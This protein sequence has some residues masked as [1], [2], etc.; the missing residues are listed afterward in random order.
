[1]TRI[2]AGVA[3][4]RRLAVP[5]KGTRPTSDRAREALFS[6]LAALLEL[7]GARVLDLYAGTG[8]VG[9]EALSR[10]AAQAVFVEDDRTAV[11]VLRRN[12]A[13]LDLPGAEVVRRRVAAFLATEPPSP[14]ELVFADPP[15]ALPDTELAEVLAALAGNG[16]LAASAVVVIERSARSGAPPWPAQVTPLH[17]RRYGEGVLWYGRAR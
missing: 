13:G 12:V 15:Y 2:V 10:G 9:L 17:E 16:W 11:E 3:K 6:S 1:M 5:D 14:S 8:A 7:A 4:G